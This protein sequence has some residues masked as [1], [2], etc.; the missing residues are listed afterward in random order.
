[1]TR[2]PDTPSFAGFGHPVRLEGDIYDLEV[3]QGEV[4]E[5]LDGTFYRVQLDPQF[6]A[7][8][9]DDMPFNADG[10]VTSFR[11]ADGHVDFKSRYVRTPRFLAERAARKALFGSYRNPFSDD[12]SVAGIVRGLAN[13]NVYFHAGRLLA[14]KEDSPPIEID[15]DTLE[16]IGPWDW[17]GALTSQTAT[18]HPK[19]D[20]T[21]GRLVFFGFAAKGEATPDIAYYEADAE[22]TIVHEAWFE[23]P[24]PSMVHDFAVTEHFVV[25]PIIPLTSSLE[26]L[27]A[28]G[29]HY[30]WDPS[31][32]VY[33]GVLPR[34][35]TSDQLRW[36]RGENRFAS[37]IMNAFDDGRYVH[38]DTPVGATSAFPFFPDLS[39]RPF[40]PERAKAYLSRWT[41]DTT[42]ASDSF[43]ETRLLDSP[44]EFPR[45]DDRVA[46]REHHFGAMAL[47]EIAGVDTY[48]PP[49]G[50]YRF[51][52][53]V[54]PASG[55]VDAHYA[56]DGSLPQEPQFVPR[57]PSADEGDG[58]VLVVVGRPAAM[59]SDLLVLDAQ[60]IAAG[61]V[62]TLA[63]PFR[64]RYGLHGNWVD[65]HDL[66][67]AKSRNERAERHR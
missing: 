2:F 32:A 63:L 8:H 54:D 13:T 20:P 18:A 35:G 43:T 56:G 66:A 60:D 42:S 49:T 59:R 39:G 33:L 16:T 9:G 5:Q 10:M 57:D 4:P 28:G 23:A 44:G 58:Y 52:A 41:M 45:I 25:F 17:H 14:S 7:L 55:Q 65:A 3:I 1:M 21:T 40:D 24:Y 12:P 19:V 51:V 27:K 36:Y 29:S 67:Q 6:P 34:G 11:F 62:A 38:V 46:T 53:V 30:A 22:G 64:L 26:R 61:P 15:P 47:T 50:G 37:H 31:E 48:G